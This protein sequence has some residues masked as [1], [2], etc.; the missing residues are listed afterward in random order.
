MLPTPV[1]W[2]AVTI[3]RVGAVHLFPKLLREELWREEELL[4]EGGV[5]C[6]KEA[7][8]REGGAAASEVAPRRRS[9]CAKEELAA[10]KRRC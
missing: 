5:C 9:C 7:L 1:H 6:E 10:R 8:L 3:H 4:R 2:F